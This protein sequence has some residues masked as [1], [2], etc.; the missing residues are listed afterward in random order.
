MTVT[1]PFVHRLFSVL[2]THPVP[3]HLNS[4][5]LRLLHASCSSECFVSTKSS[6]LCCVLLFPQFSPDML[7]V[8]NAENPLPS[9]RA[10]ILV[11][12][13]MLLL[14]LLLHK[15][16]RTKKGAPGAP[17]LSRNLQL[18]RSIHQVGGPSRGTRF[19]P[20]AL[21]QPKVCLAR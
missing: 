5:L 16:E 1:P 19:R 18:I 8:P 15:G 21:D 13:P 17:H 11:S 2:V 14:L 9:I 4:R 3:S 12:F 10:V 20:L 7:V 6:N